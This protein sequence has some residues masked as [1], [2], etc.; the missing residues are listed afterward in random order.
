VFILEVF[1][2]AWLAPLHHLLTPKAS[3]PNL[4]PLVYIVK[5]RKCHLTRSHHVGC[6]HHRTTTSIH[7]KQEK[8]ARVHNS[9][10]RLFL[11]YIQT[12]SI[13]FSAPTNFFRFRNP[14]QL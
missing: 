5:Y 10:I 11:I 7:E 3:S 1:L 6:K 13:I 2:A 14:K 9:M 8:N 12:S 4:S